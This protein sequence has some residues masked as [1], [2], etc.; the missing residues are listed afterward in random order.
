MGRKMMDVDRAWE[1]R[2]EGLSW[3]EIG[4]RL[5]EEEGRTMVY[6]ATSVQNACRPGPVRL[7]RQIAREIKRE[8]GW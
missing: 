1:L 2:D 3:R 4:I 7:A 8:L 6:Q 5:A